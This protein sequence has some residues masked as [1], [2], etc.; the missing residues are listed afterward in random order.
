EVNLEEMADI[1]VEKY[2]SASALKQR[3]IELRVS[4][5]AQ[6]PHEGEFNNKASISVNGGDQDRKSTRL[7]SSHVSISY[8]VF[9][10]KKKNWYNNVA[11]VTTDQSAAVGQLADGT[12]V[13]Q[14]GA[15][16]YTSALDRVVMLSHL[17]LILVLTTCLLG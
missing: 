14:R 9:C 13:T 1:I 2:G 7:N 16:L 3:H 11:A 12:L 4:I 17:G 5:H 15:L 6:V 10:L 8:A